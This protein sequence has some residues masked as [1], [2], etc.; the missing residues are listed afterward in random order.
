MA[1]KSKASESDESIFTDGPTS[2]TTEDM[3]SLDTLAADIRASY[4]H[5]PG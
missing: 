3:K 1:K 4:R 5:N 2:T